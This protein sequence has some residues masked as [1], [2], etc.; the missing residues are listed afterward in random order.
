M[1]VCGLQV[2]NV[3]DID[4]F[5]LSP[6]Q[7]VLSHNAGIFEFYRWSVFTPEVV[8][9]IFSWAY[10]GQGM[11]I[12]PFPSGVPARVFDASLDIAD[13]FKHMQ[14]GAVARDDIAINSF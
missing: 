2:Q 5:S 14:T 7:S 10:P 11:S 6:L 9:K 4:N 8:P 3:L 1:L 12:M 13:T